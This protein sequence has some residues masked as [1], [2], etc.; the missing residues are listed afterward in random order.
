MAEEVKLFGAW[1]SPYSR[2]IE[3]ALK[4]KGLQFEYIEENLYN[5]SPA[6]LKYNPVHKKVPV[7]VHNGKPVAESLVILEYIDETWKHNPFL[8]TDPYEKAKARFWA[9]FID[10]KFWPA[11]KKAMAS[12]G[13][14]REEAIEEA[15]QHLKTLESELKEKKIFG[16]ESLGFVDI[17]AHLLFWLVVAQEAFGVEILTEEKFPAVHELYQRLADEAVFKECMPPKE[18]LIAY[19]K[20]RLGA[21]TA[22]K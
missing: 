21:W 15:Q 20:V 18:Q 12:R 10:E 19:L 22:S 6:L 11:A 1:G 7:L 13:R 9:R 14:E 5:K 16:R 4:L 2:R 8:P 17:A 3:L